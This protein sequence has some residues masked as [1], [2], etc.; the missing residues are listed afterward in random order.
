MN[1]IRDLPKSYSLVPAKHDLEGCDYEVGIP[2]LKTVW[3]IKMYGS[4]IREFV[5]IFYACS[6]RCKAGH[7][8]KGIFFS[9]LPMFLG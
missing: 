9:A 4:V 3:A 1:H 8:C 6:Y 7:D 2:I 5:H